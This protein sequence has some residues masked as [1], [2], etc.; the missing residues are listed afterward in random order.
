[1]ETSARLS[2]T[3]DTRE[4]VYRRLATIIGESD[5]AARLNRAIGHQEAHGSAFSYSATE[6][7][8]SARRRRLPIFPQQTHA[9]RHIHIT[10]ASFSLFPAPPII[11]R[12][13]RP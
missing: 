5:V 9:I 3:R 2:N 13:E 8:L 10:I 11:E 6:A 4:I 7:T 12:S 1:M